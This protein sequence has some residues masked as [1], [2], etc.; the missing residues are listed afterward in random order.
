MNNVTEFERLRENERGSNLFDAVTLAGEI[1]PFQGDQTSLSGTDAVTGGP[2]VLVYAA[3][4]VRVGDIVRWL[5]AHY[6]V[7][8]RAPVPPFG[9]TR[10][11][12]TTPVTGR[13]PTE[14]LRSFLVDGDQ[15][16]IDGD[17]P[18]WA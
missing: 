11:L 12:T 5:G 7:L 13:F 17:R 10:V 6:K 8:S 14:I 16:L 3:Q 9:I 1:R 4:D 2:T 15:V 18:V